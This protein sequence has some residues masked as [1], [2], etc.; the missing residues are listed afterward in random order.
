V[1]A[2]IQAAFEPPRRSVATGRLPLLM[3]AFVWPGVGQFVQRRWLAGTV[4]ALA[5]LICSAV[6]F[7]QLFRILI[8][9]Y[10]LWLN[11]DSQKAPQMPSLVGLA[12]SLGIALALYVAAIVD[13]QLAQV[14]LRM[15]EN[16]RRAAAPPQG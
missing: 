11:F 3:T 13:V 5:F 6:F 8:A 12:V 1:N 14:R 10:G 15:R 9:Y 4:F 2:N 16:L 7:V